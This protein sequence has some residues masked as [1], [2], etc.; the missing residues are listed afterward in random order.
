MGPFVV[1]AAVVVATWRSV[2]V[3]QWQANH[4]AAAP[5]FAVALM[6]TKMKN[7]NMHAMVMK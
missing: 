6:S 4:P 7:I 5:D 2:R 3:R 1:V